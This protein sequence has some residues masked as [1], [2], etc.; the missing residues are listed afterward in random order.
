M[1]RTS[2]SVATSVVQADVG[3]A[4]I[5]HCTFIDIWKKKNSQDRQIILDISGIFSILLYRLTFALVSIWMLCVSTWTDAAV[6][7]WQVN[8]LPF[9]LVLLVVLHLL[10]LFTLVNI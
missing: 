8:T 1:F 10:H 6:C 2:A 3:A 7:A 4:S 9:T 5:P